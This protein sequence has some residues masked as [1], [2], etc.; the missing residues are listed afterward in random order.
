MM[1]NVDRIAELR[2]I[3]LDEAIE[4]YKEVSAAAGID[5]STY[6]VLMALRAQGKCAAFISANQLAE[7]RKA[8]E[9]KRYFH[10]D[11]IGISEST[12]CKEI[13]KDMVEIRRFLAAKR[14][15]LAKEKTF[16][17]R[18]KEEE[19]R[20]LVEEMSAQSFTHSRE[21]SAYIVRNDLGNKYKHICGI[22][23]MEMDGDVWYL[24]GG[25]SRS[26]YARLCEEL[27][28]K[29]QGSRAVAQEF[30]PYKDIP[31]H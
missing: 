9:A 26:I 10:Q 17:E 3:S 25:F 15:A 7:S 24:N 19:F 5:L 27:G 22:L 30:T 18:A 8:P 12:I 23:K 31:E 6:D 29:N 11:S 21:I 14:K 16:E 28:L 1:T 13:A 2:G 4:F 20:K